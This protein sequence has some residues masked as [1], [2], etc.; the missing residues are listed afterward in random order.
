MAS[1]RPSG[2]RSTRRRIVS[3]S[4]SD[5]G[6]FT[7]AALRIVAF[8]ATARRSRVN[9]TTPSSGTLY[10]AA[11]KIRPVIAEAAL[12]VP[13][14]PGGS[15][16][17]RY[18]WP[19]AS[20]MSNPGVT[21][22]VFARMT[23]HVASVEG[24]RPSPGPWDTFSGERGKR[25]IRFVNQLELAT[26]PSV[27]TSPASCT[28]S[29][30]KRVPTL[31]PRRTGFTRR[32]MGRRN[33]SFVEVQRRFG[34]RSTGAFTTFLRSS[35]CQS[36]GPSRRGA[37]EAWGAASAR[38]ASHATPRAL[39]A[40]GPSVRNRDMGVPRIEP[41]LEVEHLVGAEPDLRRFSAAR[42]L[43]PSSKA[44]AQDRAEAAAPGG[45]P[46]TRGDLVPFPEDLARVDERVRVHTHV[47]DALMRPHRPPVL[48]REIEKAAIPPA[49][50]LESAKLFARMIRGE[51]REGHDPG[52]HFVDPG[53]G[54]A[55][56][57]RA[58]GEPERHEGARLAHV[59]PEGVAVGA[60]RAKVVGLSL[61]DHSG[62]GAARS[63]GVVIA[64]EEARENAI[65]A[66]VVSLR[67]RRREL[68]RQ[69]GSVLRPGR[70]RPDR[71]IDDPPLRAE[72]ASERTP[73]A[74]ARPG[75]LLGEIGKVRLPARGTES[76][77][78]RVSLEAIPAPYLDVASRP[79]SAQSCGPLVH[80]L[81]G[82][83]VPE[84]EPVRARLIPVH[85]DRT[86]AAESGVSPVGESG[87]RMDV[88]DVDRQ[89]GAE[90][91]EYAVLVREDDSRLDAPGQEID[92]VGH[93]RERSEHHV[94]HRMIGAVECGS[95]RGIVGD[96]A[97]VAF[98]GVGARRCF[99]PRE[100]G[101][102]WAKA[103]GQE[104]EHERGSAQ[105]SSSQTWGCFGN[106]ILR[107]IA[108][109]LGSARMGSNPG[110][111]LMK[112]MSPTCSPYARSRDRSDCSR[113]PSFAWITAILR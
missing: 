104:H 13:S 11:W 102:R 52:S 16:L 108:W 101:S 64:Q 40:A 62:L 37:A 84:L 44:V 46:E 10:P 28:F 51:P 68:L 48:R 103:Q 55:D 18:T 81:H 113:S 61:R 17:M 7:P 107:T 80:S 39:I 75:L 32:P 57:Q 5:I 67:N 94:L 71:G 91:R 74:Q 105:R 98:R 63:P 34:L 60:G 50:V 92:R 95:R 1:Q 8:G 86:A 26:S 100:R 83:E 3:R 109:N 56:G 54:A 12:V 69:R 21:P 35:S 87:T 110:S 89:G 70:P 112:I 66:L 97:P 27:F 43:D 30:P 15:N 19:V 31:R 85:D 42:D 20:L 78:A 79:G 22:W 76:E 23:V 49:I 88:A 24:P 47:V 73:V 14:S 38:S 53:D 96:G 82:R 41:S 2:S 65:G 29:P 90:A 99:A 59:A 33:V 93:D 45:L 72:R 106:P 25:P 4:A 111:M 77:E 36:T 6:R 58:I 9:V